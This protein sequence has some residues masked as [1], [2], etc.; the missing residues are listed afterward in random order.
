MNK[1]L[2]KR[3]LKK[4]EPT[5]GDILEALLD[6]SGRMDQKF[7]KIDERFE[8]IEAEIVG[9]KTELIAIRTE[10]TDMRNEIRHIWTKL[11]DIDGRLTRLER[12]TIEDSDSQGKSI[13]DL[14]VRVKTIEKHLA[15]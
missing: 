6:F 7:E 1:I 4:V 13:V 8:K 11:D 5:T 9:I 14:Q 12:R 15:F 3:P 2:D 10:I